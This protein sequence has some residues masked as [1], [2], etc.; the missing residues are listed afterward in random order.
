[1]LTIGWN[2][3]L[4]PVWAF[5]TTVGSVWAGQ[6]GSSVPLT[7]SMAWTLPSASPNTLASRPLPCRSTS[8]GWLSPPWPIRFGKPARI[9]GSWWT[10]MARRS[11]PTW[12][13]ASVTRT[14]IVTVYCSFV[15]RDFVDESENAAFQKEAGTLAR[16]MVPRVPSNGT[17]PDPVPIVV[18]EASAGSAP[19]ANSTLYV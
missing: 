4:T 1:L 3:G 12:P 18:K 5:V 19:G 16:S 6:P 10:A 17:V 9:V 11:S 8:A 7:M 14:R 15:S 13:L 2:P